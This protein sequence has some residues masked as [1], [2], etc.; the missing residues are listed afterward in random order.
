MKDNICVD[1][2]PLDCYAENISIE[3]LNNLSKNILYTT[4]KIENCKN[5]LSLY[6]KI[7]ADKNIIDETTNKI[8]PG[9]GNYGLYHFKISHFLTREDIFPLKKIQFENYTFSCPNNSENFL[10][11]KYG[12]FMKFPNDVGLNKHLHIKE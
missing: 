5:I 11:T 1:L 4:R 10:S 6:K 7:L 8:A 9:I 12:D 3:D 2:F